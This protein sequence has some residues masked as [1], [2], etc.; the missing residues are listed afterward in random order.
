MHGAPYRISP[1]RSRVYGN[2]DLALIDCYIRTM[3]AFISAHLLRTEVFV[4]P[5]AFNGELEARGRLKPYF[6][7]RQ[8]SEKA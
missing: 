5:A 1:P 6:V 4:R 2:T 8:E 7:S 3:V